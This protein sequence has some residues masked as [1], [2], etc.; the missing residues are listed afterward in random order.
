MPRH[1][2]IVEFEDGH[3]LQIKASTACN[4]MTAALHAVNRAHGRVCRVY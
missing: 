4:A 1:T 3:R 2:Y